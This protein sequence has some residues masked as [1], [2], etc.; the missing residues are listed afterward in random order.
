MGMTWRALSAI[1]LVVLLAGCDGA[2]G[3]GSTAEPTPTGFEALP[4]AR[5]QAVD[6]QLTP[7]KIGRCLHRERIDVES[8]SGLYSSRSDMVGD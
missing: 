8:L 1:F 4:S 5:P 2:T 6:S 7:D 3:E